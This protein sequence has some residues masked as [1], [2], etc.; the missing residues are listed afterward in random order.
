[1]QVDDFPPSLHANNCL[2]VTDETKSLSVNS[3][4]EPIPMDDT[5]NKTDKDTE[6]SEIEDA[7]NYDPHE[8]IEEMPAVVEEQQQ[9]ST[10][11]T[12]LES[13]T[14]RQQ[15]KKCHFRFVDFKTF[16]NSTLSTPVHDK[17]LKKHQIKRLQ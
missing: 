2:K 3:A 13:T 12:C 17:Y 9:P 10:T 6:S 5:C 14:I 4:S 7:I 1:M 16:Y 15:S 8:T 11:S